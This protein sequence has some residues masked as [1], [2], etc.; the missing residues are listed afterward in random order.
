ML[1][2]VPIIFSVL[3]TD[4]SDALK[5]L[6][7]ITN[8]SYVNDPVVQFGKSAIGSDIDARK[9]RSFPVGVTPYT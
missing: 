1:W 4:A 7:L 8:F 5:W 3:A 2:L 6:A 9:N